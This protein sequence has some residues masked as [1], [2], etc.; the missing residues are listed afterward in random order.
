MYIVDDEE[1]VRE[2]VRIA[3]EPVYRVRTFP[4]AE[5][6]LATV[7]EETPDLILMDIGLPGM[8]GIDAIRAVKAV[9]P[10]VVIVVIT[11]YEDV[12]TVVQ[13]MKAGAFDY[14]VKP[15]HA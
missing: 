10:E 9:R 2:G 11:A 5:S 4:D 3:L 1:S 6:A 12:Q 7:Q 13:A 8:C 14:V 15:L